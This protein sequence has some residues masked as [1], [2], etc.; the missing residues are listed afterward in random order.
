MGNW[1]LESEAMLPDGIDEFARSARNEEFRLL[2]RLI[3]DHRS[4]DNVFA[5]PGD[6]LTAV[7]E[8]GRLVGIGG[9]NID[10]FDGTGT[11]GRLR[12]L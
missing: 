5:R 7:R 3:G 10:P 6:V 8:N 4:G 1:A 9:L 2:D 12:L 11:T